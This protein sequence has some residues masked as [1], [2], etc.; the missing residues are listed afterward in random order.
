MVAAA[1]VSSLLAAPAAGQV[2]Y[3][4]DFESGNTL[5]WSG[6]VPP[7]PPPTVYRHLDLDLRDPHV[8]VDV[9]LVGCFDF[10]DQ[11][12]PGNLAPSLND[13]LQT[14]IETD[15][16]GDGLLDLSVLLGFRPLDPLA[17]GERLDQGFGLC[18]APPGAPVCD[19]DR[20]PVPRTTAYDGQAIGV[21]L[22]PLAGT[23]SGYSPPVGEPAAP[24]FASDPVT[25]PLDLGGGLVVDLVDGR[26]GARFVGAPVTD[27]AD[28][29]MIGFLS[30]ADADSILLPPEL[31][32]VGGEPLSILFPGGTGNCAAG[33]DRDLHGGETGWWLYLNYAAT[34]VAFVGN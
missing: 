14:A 31:P 22:A 30:E 17:S 20:S 9:P 1:F 3:G 21:C 33:D 4:D 32:L 7:E 27:L 29:L 13:Q 6:R 18:T 10:T 16:D 19:W 28:G 26:T 23:T 25:V 8:F 2:F 12:L 5:A 34:E 15:G 24:C 11:P